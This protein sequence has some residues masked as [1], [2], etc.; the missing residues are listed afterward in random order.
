MDWLTYIRTDE[1]RALK[2]IYANHRLDCSR[3]LMQKFGLNEIDSKDVF[4]LS[5]VI[6]YDNVMTGKLTKLNSNL[7]TYLFSIARNQATNLIRKSKKEEQSKVHALLSM[8]VVEETKDDHTNETDVREVNAQ[9]RIMG[10]PCKTLLQLYY[11]EEMKM[12][13]ITSLMGYSNPNTTKAKKYQC[14]KRLQSMFHSQRK[15]NI[16]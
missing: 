11:F 6:L 3:W 10:D 13:D 16:A 12:K 5:M 15:L 9:L 2:E 14:L 4:Q 8:Y 7:K 1:N